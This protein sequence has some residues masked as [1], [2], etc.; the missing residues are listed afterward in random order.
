MQELGKTC[1]S[2]S[3]SFSISLSSLLPL[4]FHSMS[5]LDTPRDSKVKE[6]G[7]KES[8]AT[9]SLIQKYESIQ[10]L[11]HILTNYCVIRER[12]KSFSLHVLPT[13][14]PKKNKIIIIIIIIKD[15]MRNRSCCVLYFSTYDWFVSICSNH[16][17]SFTFII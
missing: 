17:H 3:L 10:V 5:E 7:L 13:S 12:P 8:K 1:S 15:K 6:W 16:K 4:N 14:P 11:L 2:Q 9:L